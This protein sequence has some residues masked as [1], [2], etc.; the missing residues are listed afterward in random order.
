MFKWDYDIIFS[1]I[2]L[3]GKFWDSGLATYKI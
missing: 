2:S 3:S 1:V